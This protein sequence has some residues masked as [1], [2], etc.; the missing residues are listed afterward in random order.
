[1]A[2]IPNAEEIERLVA[3]RAAESL[4]LEFKAAPWD[5]NDQGKREA[6]KDIT[7]MANT[8]GG[9]ILIGVAEDNNAASGLRPVSAEAAETERSRINDLVTAG[10]EPRLYG[11]GIEAVP[12]DSGVVLALHIPRSPSRPH[13]VS[14]G[15]SNRFWL[16][17]S[18]GT[19]EANV[20]D[21]RNLFLQS[22]EI[23][24][25]AMRYHRDRTAVIRTGDIVPNLSDAPGSIIL[26]IVHGDAFSGASPVDPKRAFELGK[27]FKPLGAHD[28]TS[29]FA[30]D[31]FLNLRGGP[32]CH[33]YTLVRRDGII[34]SI[35]VNLAG[36]AERLPVFQIEASVVN[37]TR[38]FVRG[39]SEL[40]IVPPYY[41]YLTL[42]G[43]GGRH[44]VLDV[45]QDAT[46]PIRPR[47][48]HLP[49]AIVEVWDS[50][51][52]ISAA[53]RPAFDAMWNAGGFAESLSYKTGQ[54]VQE[55]RV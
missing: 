22:A 21:L 52:A 24:E 10:V 37:W 45:Y 19:Y 23:T 2:N 26:H 15:G 41:V 48:L 35:K 42:E 31:G 9:L 44:I 32:K 17:N 16:R 49:V 46:E 8:R 29:S 7:A 27:Y 50:V 18:T 38:E 28:C 39:L 6:L 30:F 54:W 11:V 40:D 33:G 55:A 53:L 12:V 47:D 25:R 43:A 1:M 14:S 36:S 51:D 3:A 4:T 13:R 20:A 34:E 5:R